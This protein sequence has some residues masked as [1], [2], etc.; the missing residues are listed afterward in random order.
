MGEIKT[1]LIVEAAFLSATVEVGT[2]PA[3]REPRGFALASGA[4]CPPPRRRVRE[5]VCGA[6][7][8]LDLPAR[9]L[10]AE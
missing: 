10:H 4:E 1:G 5:M 7:V 8:N 3:L 2:A 9:R 6:R